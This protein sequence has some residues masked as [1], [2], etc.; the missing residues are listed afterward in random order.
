MFGDRVQVWPQL[1]E[2]KS[3]G[4]RDAVIDD[5]KIVFLEIKSLILEPKAL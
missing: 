5:V 2:R 3:S 1:V 4:D